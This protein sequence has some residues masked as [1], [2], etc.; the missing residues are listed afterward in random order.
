[1]LLNKF[2]HVYHFMYTG[3]INTCFIKGNLPRLDNADRRIS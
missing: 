2:I 3:A 1:M